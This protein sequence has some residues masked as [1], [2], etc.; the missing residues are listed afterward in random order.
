MR[1]RR[2]PPCDDLSGPTPS[3]SLREEIPSACLNC[4]EKLLG[5]FCSQC[6]Q[7]AADLHR[8]LR[9]LTSDFLDNVLNL[10]TRLL[11]TIPL[12]FRPGRLTREYRAGRRARY[13]RPLRL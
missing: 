8:P 12:L 4:G 13:V 5:N 2:G 6:G 10:D 7:E 9:E 11:R 3:L 1:P